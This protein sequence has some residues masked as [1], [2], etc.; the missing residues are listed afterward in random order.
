VTEA[1]VADTDHRRGSDQSLV[2]IVV[3]EQI[4]QR[5]ALM[6]ILLPSANNVS[7]MITRLVDDSLPAFVARMNATARSLGMEH[8]SYT[9]PS[10]FDDGTVSTAADQ[11]ILAR[12]AGSDPTL[13]AMVST[14]EY[15]IPVQGR[16]TNTDLL[17]G[18][19]GFVGIKTGSHESA[20]GCFMFH[21]RRT[22]DG[23]TVDIWGV[24]MGQQ[25]RNLLTAGL[26]AARQLVVAVAPMA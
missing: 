20:G 10:G 14:M 15:D 8:T 21:A 23:R 6:A 26:Y 16:V 13:A 4:S 12:T 25:G 1:D 22:L 24:V 2:D 11:L 17:L 19:D 7:V 18:E 3:G 5:A 9:D